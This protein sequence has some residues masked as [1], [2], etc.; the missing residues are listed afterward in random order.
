MQTGGSDGLLALGVGEPLN[1]I[2]PLRNQLAGH[3]SRHGSVDF[4]SF[5]A[6]IPRIIV[7]GALSS[8]TTASAMPKH[9]QH[10][11]P[12]DHFNSW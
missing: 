6:G 9:S 4:E 8:V 10:S 11:M 3:R 7:T 1:S 5:I 12:L 2:G